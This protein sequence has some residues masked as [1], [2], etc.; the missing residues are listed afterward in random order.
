MKAFKFSAVDYLLKPIIPEELADAIQRV[1]KQ[2]QRFENFR[3]FKENLQQETLTK[4]AV[5]SGNTLLFLETNKIMYIKGEG[6]YSEV[7]CS[8]GTKQL[9]SRNLKNFE[10]ILCSDS[11][12][13]RIHKSYIVNF[14]FVTAF[15]KSDGGSIELENKTQ[16][17][18][19]PDK[20]QTIL[21]NIY[22]I[23]RYFISELSSRTSFKSF[24][25][26]GYDLESTSA[27]LIVFDTFKANGAKAIAILWS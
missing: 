23:K 21:V 22:I 26:S 15:N 18:V 17:R 12:F 7:F 10:D 6:A 8:D 2:K 9:V 20:S 14:N 11:R 16:I 5:P 25:K 19:S 24:Q 3:A 13:L 27:L 1:A 4:I